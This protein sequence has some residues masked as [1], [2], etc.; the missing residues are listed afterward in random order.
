[1][2]DS[3]T[4]DTKRMPGRNCLR[5]KNGPITI[6]PKAPKGLPLDF[7]DVNWFKN[8]LPAQ[9]QNLVNIDSVYFLPDPLYSLRSKDPLEKLSN[10]QWYQATK[11]Y[12]L[13]F[14]EQQEEDLPSEDDDGSNYGGSIDL[15]DTNGEEDCCD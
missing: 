2:K 7:Y 12:N 5:V 13:D 1:M 8:N 10:T 6:F 15:Q 9:R 3:A 14:M 4:Q 11:N